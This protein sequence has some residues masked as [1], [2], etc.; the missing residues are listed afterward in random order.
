MF[1]S[2]ITNINSIIVSDLFLI[3]ADY[4]TL[5]FMLHIK[6]LMGI[7]HLEHTG[8]SL[9]GELNSQ[10]SNVQFCG[11]PSPIFYLNML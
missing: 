3:I 4:F 5:V 8:V 2:Y 9:V 10:K 1:Y 11:G 7:A 6:Y